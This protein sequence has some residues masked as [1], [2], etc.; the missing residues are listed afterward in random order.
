MS[1]NTT[2][3]VGERIV[4]DIVLVLGT[5]GVGGVIASKCSGTKSHVDK[6]TVT[7]TEYGYNIEN[8][9]ARVVIF[10][11]KD[12]GSVPALWM[13][14]ELK[15]LDPFVRSPYQVVKRLLCKQL[16]PIKLLYKSSC[17][18]KDCELP[19]PSKVV[20]SLAGF[21]SGTIDAIIKHIKC[22]GILSE[23]SDP[24]NGKKLNPGNVLNNLHAAIVL[25]FGK[26]IEHSSSY[27][28]GQLQPLNTDD[29]KTTHDLL[30]MFLN[31]REFI[32]NDYYTPPTIPRLQTNSCYCVYSYPLQDL[33]NDIIV[34]NKIALFPLRHYYEVSCELNK[35]KAFNYILSDEQ[36]RSTILSALDT[37]YKA[38]DNDDAL[39]ASQ[40]SNASTLYIYLTADNPSETLEEIAKPSPTE[41]LKV[42]G[43]VVTAS[44]TLK[45]EIDNCCTK[46]GEPSSHNKQIDLACKM[47]T[48]LHNLCFCK[49]I[50]ET[51]K[52]YT[53]Y[54]D[55]SFC[56]AAF[57]AKQKNSEG[58]DIVS[59]T[60]IKEK[61]DK[62]V[63]EFSD[64]VSALR[65]DLESKSE[66]ES[67]SNFDDNDEEGD[68]DD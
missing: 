67:E 5:L 48:Q 62:K 14:Y 37:K 13:M 50:C 1:K 44:E 68:D 51:L 9:I 49:E 54:E 4:K 23:F 2:M 52:Y 29:S 10:S 36:R 65:A 22:R 47:E 8:S 32:K 20:F 43:D 27:L 3:T 58:E 53:Y 16:T 28:Q 40:N 57:I 46:G 64:K 11:A 24:L 66:F 38:F 35:L 15:T 39:I 41:I 17:Y 7:Q 21:P 60:T 33:M 45:K 18:I 12:K 31:A 56:T 26:F 19:P 42:F 61:F 6:A 59:F 55:F 25:G 30:N 34:N 63:K